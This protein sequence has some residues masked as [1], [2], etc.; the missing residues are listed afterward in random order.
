MTLTRLM[1]RVR[2]ADA[3]DVPDL[4]AEVDAY[5]AAHP[6]WPIDQHAATILR[7]ARILDGRVMP[8]QARQVIELAAAGAAYGEGVAEAEAARLAMV[9]QIRSAVAAGLPEAA[10]ARVSGVT[11]MTVR[12]A[13]GKR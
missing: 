7:L 6:E 12:A 1:E 11:R 2:D 13:L 4:A 9:D 8:A 5:A 3:A 10:A